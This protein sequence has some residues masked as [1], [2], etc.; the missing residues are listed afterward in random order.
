[1]A[2]MMTSIN[3]SIKEFIEK[4]QLFFVGTAA[5]DGR[6]NI[7]PKGM[8]TLRVMDK[9][10]VLWMNLTGSG[11]ETAAHLIDTN[12][13]MPCKAISSMTPSVGMG[14]DVKPGRPATSPSR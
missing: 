7:S 6:V 1:M 12:R 8:D 13:I 9:N 14:S 3:D 11:N 2:K 4:Q 5:K 10:R